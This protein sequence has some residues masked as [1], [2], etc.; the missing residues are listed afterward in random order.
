MRFISSPHAS[1][2]SKRS[3]RAKPAQTWY[4]EPQPVQKSFEWMSHGNSIGN[5]SII[6][7]MPPTGAPRRFVHHSVSKAR[8]IATPSTGGRKKKHDPNTALANWGPQKRP[9]SPIEYDFRGRKVSPN[10]RQPSPALAKQRLNWLKSMP[11]SPYIPG[12]YQDAS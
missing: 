2:D 12:K 7:V 1:S 6:A 8:K 10:K 11:T 9:K 3:R 5:G 4:K